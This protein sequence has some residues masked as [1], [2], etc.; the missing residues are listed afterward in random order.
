MAFD[1]KARKNE[2]RSRLELLIQ[3]LDEGNE[4]DFNQGLDE[5]TRIHEKELFVEVGKLTRELHEALKGFRMDFRL[6]ELAEKEMPD[7]R[8]RLGYVIEMTEK[9]AHTT[10]ETVESLLPKAER[11]GSE[12]GTLAA[13][14]QRFMG[15]DMEAAEFRRMAHRLDEFLAETGQDVESLRTGL[16][17]ILMSQ[18]YQDLTGQIIGR[19]I[20]MVQELEE[21]MVDLLRVA[22]AKQLKSDDDS[23]VNREEQ[24]RS[25][26]RRGHGPATPADAGN[27]VAQGQDD[28]DDLLSSLGF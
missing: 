13:D 19:V 23:A 6:T 11:I 17:D 25:D 8:D 26:D 4:A 2:Y 28:V 7:A 24:V 9:A 12:A 21:G 18:E 20:R 1:D 27:E 5:L 22:G 3:A 15:R 10:L 14:W 16:T